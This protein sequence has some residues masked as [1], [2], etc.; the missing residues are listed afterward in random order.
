MSCVNDFHNP[1]SIIAL[2]VIRLEFHPLHADE[3]SW[4]SERE[5]G[6]LYPVRRDVAME[7]HG[8]GQRVRE[9]IVQ[10]EAEVRACVLGV[11]AKVRK[12]DDMV[13]TLGVEAIVMDDFEFF[14][15][16]AVA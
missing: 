9:H 8:A 13:I 2:C 5:E 14:Q 3:K 7:S 4:A 6:F 16:R 1:A 10:T 12:V 15:Q 11:S